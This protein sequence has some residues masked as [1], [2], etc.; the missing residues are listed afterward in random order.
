MNKLKFK[1]IIFYLIICG[2]VALLALILVC[3]VRN[4][5]P[6][7]VKM[8]SYMGYIYLI[9]SAASIF[10]CCKL[11]L[12]TK[13]NTGLFIILLV[14]AALAP[15]LI[16]VYFVDTQPF[17]DFLH[18]HNYGVSASQGNFKG[19][20]NFYAVFPFK[21][22]FGM[23]LAGL[24]SVFGSGLMVA[25]MFNAVLS[26]ILVMLIYAGGRML[27][28]EKAGRIA[29]LM[30]AF[31]PAQIM[32]TSVIASEHLFMV[33]F[34]GSLLLILRFI[35]RYTY[36]NYEIGS[37]NLI[38]AGIG[39]LTA[40][41]QLVR[42]MAMLLLPVFA[43]FVLLYKK[44]RAK[45]INSTGLG[46]KSIV[47]VLICYFGALNIVNIPVQMA[48][49][50]DITKSDGGFNLMI[51]TNTKY[52]G[53]FNKEDFGI[54]EK[55]AY[56]FDKV[57]KEAKQIAFTRLRSSPGQL[58]NLIKNKF[59]ILWG[60][61]NYGYYWSTVAAHSSEAEAV[62][63]SHPRAFYGL[64]QFFYVLVILMALCSCFYTLREKRYDALVLLMV[65]GGIL[66]SYTLLEVQA[67]YH[68]PVI[69][70]LILFGSG[71]LN[72]AEGH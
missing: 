62:I 20:V 66:V 11:N 46:I 18:I 26:I 43:V 14:L 52:N 48:T 65:F 19:F 53:V 42:P 37:G 47:L 30:T 17:S 25:K 64:A 13:I 45:A 57:H 23:V 32:Y 71:F 35:K 49:G 12:I 6:S 72:E 15:R 58:R 41:A 51:G 16:W 8:P 54:I 39:L 69:P 4:L 63:K 29:A 38:L 70:V 2:A 5:G 33:L 61:E 9:L 1:D 40:A 68:M 34:T 44:Y 28:S 22:G 60:N 36:K 59:E 24:Y 31:W 50:V 55:N 21:I 67:R 27:Y 3:V 7:A 56:D 10:L